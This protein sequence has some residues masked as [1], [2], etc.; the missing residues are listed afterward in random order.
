MVPID[1]A[2]K[3]V[4]YA[5]VDDLLQDN[6][7]LGIGSGSTVIP[8]VTRIAEK[9]A[10]SN[11]KIKC[12]PT[13]F[14]ARQLILAHN[15]PLYDLEI[16]PELDLTIDGAD[17]VERS[18]KY[19]IKGG[20]GCLLQEKIVASASKSLAIICDYTK[21]S[22]QLG[23]QWKKGI[24]IEVAPISH[25]VV[26]RKIEFTFGGEANLRMA[27]AKAG[28]LVTDN[29]NFILDWDFTFKEDSQMPWDEI[30]QSLM[31]IPGIIDTGLF[32]NMANIV[33]YAE[34]DGSVH[35]I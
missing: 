18:T 7:V 12:I 19:C 31:M 15:L 1:E 26:K 25:V 21:I 27:K 16:C 2:K 6:M 11:L 17:E 20:G 9:V 10:Q 5:A 3:I 13:S 34:K 32:I 30:N 29:G 28:P 24:P 23:D 22:G 14:Q 33:Y 35:K 8:A 4:A